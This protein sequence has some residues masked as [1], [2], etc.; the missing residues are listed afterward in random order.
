MQI[1]KLFL[2]AATFVTSYVLPT[3]CGDFL[4]HPVH[5]F[6]AFYTPS[7]P[8]RPKRAGSRMCIDAQT[9]MFISVH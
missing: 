1:T 6:Y 9:A 4:P 2:L 3:T 7:P 8:F 5:A